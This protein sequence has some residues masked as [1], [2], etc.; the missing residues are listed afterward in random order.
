MVSG[1]KSKSSKAVLPFTSGE[2]DEF[3]GA[4]TS[5]VVDAVAAMPG[6]FL[7][8]GAGG[9][10]GLHVCLML[11][12]ALAALGRRD[13]VTAVSRFRTLRDRAAFE[14]HGIIAHACDLL[15][16]SDI[17][18]LPDAPTA[19]YLAGAKFGTAA[20]PALLRQ[21][22]VDMPR[23]VAQRLRASRIIAFS[24]GCVYPFMRPETGGAIE[25]TPVAPVGDYAA[26][27]VAREQAFTAAAAERGTRLALIRLNYSVEFRY[28]VLVDIAQRVLRGDSVDV[29]T[30]YANVIWQRDAVGHTIQTAVLAS[31][32]P[33]VINITGAEILSVRAVAQRFGELL[34]RPVHIAGREAETAWLNNASYSHRLFGAPE[35]STEQMMQW[36]AAWL[37]EGGATWGKPTAFESRNGQF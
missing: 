31:Q 18:G 4:P 13:D 11:R 1:F 30:G 32:I 17:A 20:N 14:Q 24:S 26:S 9:K 34:G 25:D 27:C 12:R 36:I 3:L 16:S 29:T 15:D 22:N 37:A 5:K 23:I 8:L 7:V 2:V 28:G 35:I 6:S 33:L 10:M 19:F 21:A